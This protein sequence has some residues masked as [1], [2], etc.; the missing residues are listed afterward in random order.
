MKKEPRIIDADVPHLQGIPMLEPPD[1]QA[2]FA[3]L[4]VPDKPVMVGGVLGRTFE[5]RACGLKNFRPSGQVVEGYWMCQCG[6]D[7]CEPGSPTDRWASKS[8]REVNRMLHEMG[9]FGK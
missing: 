3:R 6:Y 1:P 4:T 7:N 9:I 8:V 5:C 2:S